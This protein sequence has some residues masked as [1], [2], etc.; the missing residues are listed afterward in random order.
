MKIAVV[1]DIH[2]DLA[3]FQKAVARAEAE[4]ASKLICVGDLVGYSMP[5]YGFLAERDANGVVDAVR[6]ECDVVVL[7]NHDLYALRRL[8]PY[9][10]NIPKYRDWYDRDYMDRLETAAGELF[11][12]EDSE[13][14]TL[15][16][17]KNLEYLAGLPLSEQFECDGF[18]ILATHYAAPDISGSLTKEVRTSSDAQSHLT[19][20]REVGADFGFSG[21]D[22]INGFLAF[23]ASKVKKVGF[24]QLMDAELGTWVHGP[25]IARGT[26][27]NGFIVFDT[28][29]LAI[30]AVPLKSPIHSIPTSI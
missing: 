15:L 11:L 21:N 13:L 19:L 28:T 17:R 3:S 1:S 24:Q 25:A 30:T 23:N 12:Y 18:S 29:D 27:P 7:G 22:H 26:T 16:T 14:S 4:G 2:E 9:L 20:M 8:P 6:Y 5:F 10:E